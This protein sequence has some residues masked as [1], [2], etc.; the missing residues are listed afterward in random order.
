MRN[1]CDRCK[2]F[3]ETFDSNLCKDCHEIREW[4]QYQDNQMEDTKNEIREYG[5][6]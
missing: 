5:L 3:K 4:Q 2:L 1:Y 6:S